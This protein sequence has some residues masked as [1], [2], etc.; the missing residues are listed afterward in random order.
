MSGLRCAAGIAMLIFFAA[1]FAAF[2]MPVDV[3]L[4]VMTLALALWAGLGTVSRRQ[5]R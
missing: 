2:W 4:P 3:A 1:S 5:S